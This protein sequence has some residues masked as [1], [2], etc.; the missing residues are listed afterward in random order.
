MLVASRTSDVAL[1]I[2]TALVYLAAYFAMT[3][4]AFG[5]VAVV[6]RAEAGRDADAVPDF[7]GLFWRRP[8]LAACFAIVLLSLAG[9]P[10]TLGFIAKFYLFTAGVEGALWILLWALIVGSGIGLFYYLRIIFAMTRTPETREPELTVRGTLA[11]RSAI[12]ALAL[13][14]IVLG[15]YPTPLIDLVRTAVAAVGATTGTLVGAP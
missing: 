7:D 1:G 4:G 10:M 8:T 2:E 6:S 14:L 12:V 9:I 3:L 15:I 5:I 13:V 11:D